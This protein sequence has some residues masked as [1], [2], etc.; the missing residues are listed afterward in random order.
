VWSDGSL[1]ALEARCEIGEVAHL[2]RLR[3]AIFAPAAPREPGQ[4]SAGD[5]PAGTPLVRVTFAAPGGAEVLEVHADGRRVDRTPAHGER[6][7][8]LASDRV[9][10]IRAA[11]AG[12]DWAALPARLC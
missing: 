8:Q 4:S 1:V 12:T 11:V 9:A 2:D 7:T 10:A 6:E 3:D 5:P